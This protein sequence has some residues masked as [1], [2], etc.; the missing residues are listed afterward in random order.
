MS[1]PGLGVEFV[2]RRPA[3]FWLTLRLSLLTIL[4]LGLYRFWMKTRLR[5]WYWSAV[6]IGGLPVEYTGEALEKLLG[7]LIAVVFLA[8]YIGVVN[9]LLMFLSFSLFNG[10]VAAYALSFVGVLPVLFYARYRA[11]RYVLG[12]TRWRG[13]RLGMAPGAWGYAWRALLHWTLTLLSLGL[14]W[15]RMTFWLEKYRTDRTYFGSLALIQGGRWTMLYRAARH[16]FIGLALAVAG[17]GALITLAEGMLLPFG[18]GAAGVLLAGGLLWT[19]VGIVHYRVSAFRLLTNAKRLEGGGGFSSHARTGRV[20]AIYVWGYL[21]AFLLLLIVL[22]P[23]ALVVLGLLAAVVVELPRD[24]EELLLLADTPLWLQVL[25][26]ALLYFSFF[27]VLGV[28]RQ[29]FVTMPLVRHY[30]Q[31]LRITGPMALDGARQRHADRFSEAEGFAEAL[32][33]GAAF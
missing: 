25:I 8:F 6:R 4:T 19:I 16:V 33:V 7:F 10:A 26:G 32:D 13:I 11:R 31:T 24:A 29:V 12:R 17:G 23:G 30:T 18:V 20:L 3:L 15:P 28:L 21:L 5:R 27:V 14:L 9:L 1:A 22:L 2:G